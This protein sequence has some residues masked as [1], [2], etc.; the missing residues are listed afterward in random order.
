MA[1]EQRVEKLE[2]EVAGLLSSA[3]PINQK[4]EALKANIT[5]LSILEKR[6]TA[7][8]PP[9]AERQAALDAAA[10]HRCSFQSLLKQLEVQPQK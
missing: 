2:K 8:T 1:L 5:L 9:S 6:V 4:A 10:R 3:Q 7:T